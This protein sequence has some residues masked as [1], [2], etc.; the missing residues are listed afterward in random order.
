MYAVSSVTGRAYDEEDVRL[1]KTCTWASD[2]VL[3]GLDDAMSIALSWRIPTTTACQA[4][5]IVLR[6]HA[7]CFVRRG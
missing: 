3:C 1:D 5:G 6:R 2:V 7:L 4:M